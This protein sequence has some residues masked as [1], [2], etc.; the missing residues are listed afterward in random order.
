M[1]LFFFSFSDGMGMELKKFRGE[2]VYIYFLLFK[3]K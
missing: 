3:P 1:K 2:K